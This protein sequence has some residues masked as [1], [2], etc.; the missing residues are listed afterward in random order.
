[1]LIILLI[2]DNLSL[3]FY[4]CKK[5]IFSQV[6]EIVTETFIYQKIDFQL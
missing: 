5:L 4:N 3:F 2:V 1:M 6:N